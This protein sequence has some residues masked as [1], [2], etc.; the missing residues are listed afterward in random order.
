MTMI[1]YGDRALALATVLTTG[2]SVRPL[3]CAAHRLDKGDAFEV[4]WRQLNPLK[5]EKLIFIDPPNVP[6]KSIQPREHYWLF[7]TDKIPLSWDKWA[8][9]NGI[10]SKACVNPSAEQVQSLLVQGFS[11]V[12][13][14][15]DAA[16][17]YVRVNGPSMV[18]LQ[19]EL[20]KFV[21]SGIT[22]V[23]RE[24]AVRLIGGAEVAKA[25]EILRALGTERGI[26]LMAEITDKNARSLRAY[27]T[28]ALAS[29]RN[30]W[31]TALNVLFAGAD[32]KRYDD[33]TAA[34]LFA[35]HCYQTKKKGEPDAMIDTLAIAGTV[36][37]YVPCA[38]S[39][40]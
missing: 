28:K 20:S 1:L 34:Q 24:T 27:L 30:G 15:A 19:N 3:D 16:E 31:V 6:P 12:R 32:A 37:W 26:K 35:H 8:K 17:W 36:R 22:A 38:S 13:F 2:L 9:K 7:F 11:G 5:R 14:T 23:D 4:R 29:R 25:D 10:P 21:I 33:W 39:S 18:R 40:T